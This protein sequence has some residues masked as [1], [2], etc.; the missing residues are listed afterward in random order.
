MPMHD[1]PDGRENA[2]NVID[3]RTHLRRRVDQAAQDNEA[4]EHDQSIQEVYRRAEHGDGKAPRL[5]WYDG[6][7]LGMLLAIG[8]VVWVL[9]H[10]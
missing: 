5:S 6:L 8:Y 1:L 10:H 3:F 4:P 2:G 9:I 7:W